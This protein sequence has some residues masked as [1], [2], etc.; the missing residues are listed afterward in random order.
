MRIPMLGLATVLALAATLTACSTTSSGNGGISAAQPS[1]SI[2]GAPS[3]PGNP[4]GAPSSSAGPTTTTP[5]QAPASPTYGS[6]AQS[7]ATIALTAFAN[8]NTTLLDDYTD[9]GGHSSFAHIGRSD[10]HW[11]FHAC[12]PNGTLTECTFDNNVGDRISVEIKPGLLA[13]PHA[14]DSAF[15]DRIAYPST[16]DSVVG[17]F[18]SAWQ[19][20]NRY[21]MLALSTSGVV[22]GLDVSHP[23]ANDTVQT[24]DT[25]SKPHHTIVTV[26]T[27]LGGFTFDVSDAKLDGPHAITGRSA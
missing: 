6:S 1:A 17:Y 2:S 25:T 22:G 5:T 12:G 15:I 11:H 26:E 16:A 13:K 24:D 7:Y 20:G 18:I 21:R 9:V 10:E 8:R 19:N 4:S 23:P 27:D 14:V 3:A